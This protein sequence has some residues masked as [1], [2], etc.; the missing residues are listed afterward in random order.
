M[1]ECIRNTPIE[2]L[3]ADMQDGRDLIQIAASLDEF[4]KRVLLKILSGADDELAIPR[5]TDQKRERS[6]IQDD[7]EQRRHARAFITALNFPSSLEELRY[8]YLEEGAYLDIETLLYPRFRENKP[9]EWTVPKW[10]KPGDVCM[11]YF[12]KT[13]NSKLRKVQKEFEKQRIALDWATERSLEVL[14]MRGWHYF[15]NFAGTI[16]AIGKVAGKPYR[17]PEPDELNHWKSP[18]YAVIDE[19]TALENPLHISDFRDVVFITRGGTITPVFGREFDTV[20]ERIVAKNTVPK[21]FTECSTKPLPLRDINSEN[22]MQVAAEH[23]RGFI[24]E[25]EFRACYADYLLRGI[26]DDGI[27]Y[28]ECRTKKTI[29][30][31]AKKGF[32]DNAIL[33]NGRYLPVEVKLNIETE[34]DLPAQCERYCHLGSLFLTESNPVSR[35]KVYDG[36]VLVVDTD[37]LYIF[38]SK[39]KSIERILKFDDLPKNPTPG[40]REAIARAIEQR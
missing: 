30:R 16:L 10:A 1:Q 20:R 19:I 17:F 24:L 11:F 5:T 40:I 37:G 18:I 25:Q 2:G 9:V 31:K 26:S 29:K 39:T 32:V 8:N 28:R 13:A 27:L 7:S 35:K 33:F 6:Y 3:K 22:W 4:D 23:R 14:L 21:F 15:D 36:N 12:A 38:S 34:K